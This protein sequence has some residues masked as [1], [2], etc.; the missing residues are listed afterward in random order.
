MLDIFFRMAYLVWRNLLSNLQSDCYKS[1]KRKLFKCFLSFFIFNNKKKK[2]RLLLLDLV[3]LKKRRIWVASNRMTQPNWLIFFPF[4]HSS[5]FALSQNCG[6]ARTFIP[7]LGFN[8]F[9]FKSFW[10][11]KQI[12]ILWNE[13]FFG[14]C[15][16]ETRPARQADTL[17][18]RLILIKS[19]V[20]F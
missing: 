2:N 13:S 14:R 4:D 19:F 20:S 12:F 15:G 18:A 5:P 3:N 9:N 8:H 1:I 17:N 11:K 10:K 6:R 7:L 16:E